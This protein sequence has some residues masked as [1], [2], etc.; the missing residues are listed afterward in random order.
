M[1]VFE[2]LHDQA[3]LYLSSLL[4]RHV[5]PDPVGVAGRTRLQARYTTKIRLEPGSYKQKTYGA[6]SFSYF[7]PYLWNSLPNELRSSPTLETF[8]SRLKTYLFRKHYVN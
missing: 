2:I 4:R 3:P 5:P 7:A 6:R 8:K 1:I